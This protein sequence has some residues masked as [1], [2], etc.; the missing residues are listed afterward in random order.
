[1]PRG[2]R[3]ARE[4]AAKVEL[5]VNLQTAKALGIELPPALLIRADAL[6][7]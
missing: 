7:E 6:I 1:M 2:S 3:G 5:L 4:Q